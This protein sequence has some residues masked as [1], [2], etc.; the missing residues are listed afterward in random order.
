M[1]F[2]A[3]LRAER[4]PYRR[5]QKLVSTSTMSR[6]RSSV[7]D[8]DREAAFPD[9]RGHATRDTAIN[10]FVLFDQF[11]TQSGDGPRGS[12]QSGW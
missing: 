1:A 10:Y 7:T 12:A 9:V 11:E 8:A 4:R 5:A 3:R 6:T 2:S